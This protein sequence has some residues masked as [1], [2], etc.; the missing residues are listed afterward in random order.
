MKIINIKHNSKIYN[1]D[2]TVPFNFVFICKVTNREW[3]NEK[4]NRVEG[5]YI[6]DSYIHLTAEQI[7]KGWYPKET[8]F[9]FKD[10][11]NDIIAC[12]PLYNLKCKYVDET[13][14]E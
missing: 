13:D 5:Y 1:I 2:I 10:K 8:K 11:D 14:E 6:F 7:M 4:E 9:C 12:I 3:L